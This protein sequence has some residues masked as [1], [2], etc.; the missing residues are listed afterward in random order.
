MI[1]GVIAPDNPNLRSI[2]RKWRTRRGQV[3][4]DRY[5]AVDRIAKAKAMQGQ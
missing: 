3:A 1:P 2:L 4:L 5:E